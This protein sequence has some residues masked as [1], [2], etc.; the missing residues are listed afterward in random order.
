MDSSFRNHHRIERSAR[1]L[2]IVLA[3]TISIVAIPV[4]SQ[5]ATRSD[6]ATGWAHPGTGALIASGSAGCK[7]LSP[8]S[9]SKLIGYTLPAVAS[10]TFKI[11]P[12]TADFE[13]A[14]TSTLCIYGGKSADEIALTRE[15]YIT[16]EVTSK[17]VTLATMQKV[18]ASSKQTKFTFSKYVGL[19]VP[20]YYDSFVGGGG[21]TGQGMTVAT[22]STHFFAVT[23]YDSTASKS[24]LA[25]LVKLAEKI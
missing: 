1:F 17:P 11:T 24:T 2:L 12:S 18:A 3:G 16:Y 4:I 10:E 15:V 6:D 19:G 13:I 8:A 25:A 14:G 5:A 22:S 20:A 21:I 23:V 7:K 9:V